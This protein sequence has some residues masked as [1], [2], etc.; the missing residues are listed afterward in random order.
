MSRDL[1]PLV[2]ADVALF[3][4]GDEVL[5]VLL[6]RRTQAPFKG[7][8]A[9]PGSVLKPELDRG[10]EDTARRALREKLGVDVPYLQQLKVFD[11]ATRDPRGWSLSVLHCALLSRDVVQAAARSKVDDVHWVDADAI[12]KLAFDHRQQ[13]AEARDELRRRVRDQALPLHLLPERFTLS[14]LQRVCELILR[15]GADD[16]LTLDK[17]AFRR[18]LAGSN[19]FEPVVGEFVRG[20]QRPAQLYRATLGFRF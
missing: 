11:G 18:R 9:L 10:L 17:G 3:S 15:E 8:W 6:A 7:L 12:S 20:P 4:L 2:S 5:Q 14:Q 13:V 1:Y 16:P 19:D